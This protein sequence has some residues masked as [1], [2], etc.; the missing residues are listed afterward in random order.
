[1]IILKVKERGYY[2]DIPGITP[3]RTPADV[4]ISKVRIQLIISYLKNCGITKYE[5]ISKNDK[6]VL[7]SNKDFELPK[8]EKKDEIDVRLTRI[9]NAIGSRKN[10]QEEQITN[11][12][13]ALEE[14]SKKILE[15]ESVREIVYTS[16]QDVDGKPFVEELDEDPFIPD[17][18]LSDL[19]LK[20]SSSET[21]KSTDDAEEAADML[22]RLK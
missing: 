20:G 1:V 4:D 5:I 14:L 13:N 18:D 6:E 16:S 22:S 15:R 9:E 12:L 3:F 11:K 8:K 7:Y 10:L 17:I 2:L 21:I 19:K